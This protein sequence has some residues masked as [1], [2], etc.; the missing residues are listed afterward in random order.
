MYTGHE[1][2]KVDTDAYKKVIEIFGEE[3]INPVDRS[4]DRKILG[5]KV[6][7]SSDELKKLTNIVWPAILHLAQER[8][9]HLFK[10]GNIS[11]HF[12]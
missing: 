9:E 8:I 1:T 11:K 7:Q 12:A 4:I 10:E 5:K 6:F 2:Y 3:I